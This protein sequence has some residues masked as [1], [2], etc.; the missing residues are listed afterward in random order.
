MD[1]TTALLLLAAG[2]AGGIVTAVYAQRYWS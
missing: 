1:T 2:F